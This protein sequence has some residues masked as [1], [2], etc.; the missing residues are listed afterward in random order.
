MKLYGKYAEHAAAE[1][2]RIGDEAATCRFVGGLF[3][4]GETA[5][6]GDSPARSAV[7]PDERSA[8]FNL[9]RGALLHLLY[10]LG[11]RV[12]VF[13]HPT[14]GSVWILAADG[15]GDALVGPDRGLPDV[16][17]DEAVLTRLLAK[18]V[19]PF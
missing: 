9:D 2:Q 10:R 6:G 13:V 18:K 16:T 8:I 11:V 19:L 12:D 17:V 7:V 14:P 4:V 3:N 1:R 5:H 15:F